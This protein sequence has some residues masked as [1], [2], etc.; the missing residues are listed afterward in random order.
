MKMLAVLTVMLLAVGVL[1]PIGALADEQTER[2][3]A[4]GRAEMRCTLL[5]LFTN[6]NNTDTADDENATAR[7]INDYARARLS[8]LEWFED[9]T[10]LASA[11]S[12][13]RFRM[14]GLLNT[15]HAAVDGALVQSNTNNESQTY[16]T[17][18]TAVA[19]AMNQTPLA[20]IS[21]QS[22]LTGLNGTVNATIRFLSDTTGAG[23]YA[24]CFLYEDGVYY[25][26]QNNVSYHRFVARKQVNKL[27]F[28]SGVIRSNETFFANYSFSLDPSWNR[29]NM[30]ALLVLQSDATL[31]YHPVHQ[32]HLFTFG[33]GASYAIDMSPPQQTTSLVSGQSTQLT[34]Y[35]RNNGSATDTVD[36]TIGGP[37]ASWG[38]LNKASAVL[39]PT[40]TAVLSVA[41]FVPADSAAGGYKLSVRGTSRSDPTKW[42]ESDINIVVEQNMVYG[43]SVSP[44]SALEEVDAGN[45]A[46]FQLRV[47]NSGTLNDTIGLSVEGSQASWGSLS[48][49]SVYLPP[50]GEEVVTLSVSVPADSESGRYD[51]KVNAVSSG[52]PAKT[53]TSTATVKVTGKSTAVFGVGVQPATATRSLS[54]GGSATVSLTV[55]NTGN[56]NDTI[57][58]SKTG[59]AAGWAVLEPLSLELDAGQIGIVS[60]SIIVPPSTVAGQYALTVRATSRGDNTRRSES[61][62]TLDLT[63]PEEPPK[64]DMVSRTPENVTSKDLVIVT[65][66]AS[67][68]SLSYANI[69]YTEGS[70]SHPAQKMVKDGSTFTYSMGPFKESTLVKYTVTVY[71]TAGRSNRSAEYSFIVKAPPKTDDQAPGFEL[72]WVVA[73]AGMAAAALSRKPRRD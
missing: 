11:D 50:S 32:S 35:G 22:T 48:R 18:K 13:E 70:V 66:V 14:Y 56:T 3:G 26:G 17:Y 68:S 49:T 54:A 30:G 43:V 59:D 51:L 40:E 61:V 12:Q 73:A 63:V 21:G 45:T 8:V 19:T 46:T 31:L 38:S 27:S 60:V 9:G 25:K 28:R 1:I 20:A 65:V 72:L 47:R 6:A 5:E 34:V 53:A 67:G 7:I 24:Y 29:A 44:S 42:D 41:I 71:S 36:F 15:P 37:A 57:D 52:D 39:S 33:A 4:S 10:P 23:L 58:L 2:G 16:A 64:L 69:T 55:N 62:I